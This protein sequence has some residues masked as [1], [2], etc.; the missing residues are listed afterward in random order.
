MGLPLAR[1]TLQVIPKAGYMQRYRGDPSTFELARHQSR[2]STFDPDSHHQSR[3]VL[4]L[5]A[6]FQIDRIMDGRKSYQ[7]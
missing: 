5:R 7:G 4:M 1:A 6:K 2:G 3:R